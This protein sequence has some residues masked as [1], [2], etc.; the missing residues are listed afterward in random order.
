[1]KK[2]LLFKLFIFA[3]IGAFVTVTS[4]KDYDD[5]I[6]GVRDTANQNESAISALQTQLTTLQTA[7]T[8]AQTAADAAKTASRPQRSK[9]SR[10]IIGNHSAIHKAAAVSLFVEI[11]IAEVH[12]M[13]TLLKAL[14]LITDFLAD[15]ALLG[16]AMIYKEQDSHLKGSILFNI[17]ETNKNTE[18]R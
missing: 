18:T 11:I 3:V 8:T 12:L 6:S 16:K 7:A 17:S 13:P 10:A 14:Y 2:K 4:C 1:M 15:T 9:H 5:D